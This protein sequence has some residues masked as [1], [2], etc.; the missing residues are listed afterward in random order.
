MSWHFQNIQINHAV[1]L[2]G[3]GTNADEG[4]YWILR[5]SWGEGWG[6]GGFMR[7][8]RS[9]VAKCGTDDTPL[10]GVGCVDDGV[11]VQTVCG[12]CAVLFDTS[13]PIGA[14]EM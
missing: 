4:D 13:Y 1:Q 3:Y 8:R 6:E 7:L 2:V 9:D 14:Y 11:E 10:Y 5:N 12:T